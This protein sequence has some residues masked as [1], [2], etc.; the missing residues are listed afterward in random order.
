MVSTTGHLGR[1]RNQLARTGRVAAGVV[2]LACAALLV[3][4]GCSGGGSGSNAPAGSSTPTGGIGA[5]MAG[6]QVD[7]HI[8][9]QMMNAM[10]ASRA[11]ATPQ[12][13]VQTYLAWTSYAYR[14][15]ESSVASF[16]L[17]PDEDVRVDSYIQYNLEKSRLI[18]QTL[19]SISFGK[20]SVGS[21]ST[22]VPTQEKW[23]YSY[24][25]INTGNKVLGGPY[26]A[27][28]DATYT[29]VKSGKDW[30]VYSVAAKAIGTV[31]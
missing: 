30:L 28:Y 20:A 4:A 24:L 22:L 10:P 31:K 19:T 17:G 15:G 18:D 6:P 3:I 7:V 9:Q 29:V 26:Q 2:L 13:A 5:A 12:S 27:S 8:S 16:A 21:T 25:S 23:T 1:R 11:L 14:I